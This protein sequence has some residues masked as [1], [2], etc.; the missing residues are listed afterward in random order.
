[1]TSRVPAHRLPCGGLNHRC[2]IGDDDKLGIAPLIMTLFFSIGMVG[3]Q[4][5]PKLHPH[6]FRKP[7]IS[8][9]RGAFVAVG[10]Y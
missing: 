2:R 10:F 1:M 3:G 8:L 9:G 5:L 7:E 6:H 4:S